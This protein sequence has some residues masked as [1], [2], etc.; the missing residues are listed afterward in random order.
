MDFMDEIDEFIRTRRENPLYADSQEFLDK[1]QSLSDSIK[2]EEKLCIIEK[3]PS[4]RR[5]LPIIHIF[6]Y[7]KEPFDTESMRPIISR[8]GVA[9][10]GG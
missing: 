1:L 5:G 10:T 8:R 4:L 9:F 7:K 6:F 2:K 3:Q